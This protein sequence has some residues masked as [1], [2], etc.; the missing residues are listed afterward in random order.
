MF[1]RKKLL[2]S[3]GT[4]NKPPSRKGGWS[5]Y[6]AERYIQEDGTLHSYIDERAPATSGG[7]KAFLSWLCTQQSNAHYFILLQLELMQRTR[8]Y[9]NTVMFHRF[10][11]AWIRHATWR[12][13]PNWVSS[14]SVWRAPREQLNGELKKMLTPVSAAI[15]TVLNIMIPAE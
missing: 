11:A 6:Q 14:S 8:Y 13:S 1:R 12:S 7:W 15:L 3:S 5:K 10:C 4:K 9:E 2:P